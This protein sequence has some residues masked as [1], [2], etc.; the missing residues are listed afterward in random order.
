MDVAETE[1]P[2][3]MLLSEGDPEDGSGRHTSVDRK[4]T[5]S[6]D[7]SGVGKTVLPVFPSAQVARKSSVMHM[8]ARNEVAGDDPND[9]GVIGA[10]EVEA[11]AQE[12]V[13]ACP[14]G[15]ELNGLSSAGSGRA[16][17]GGVVRTKPKVAIGHEAGK[18][19]SLP[20]PSDVSRPRSRSL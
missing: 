2:M 7:E 3:A 5:A 19:M 13:C 12:N 18:G 9:T 15:N 17:V 1:A 4:E 10:W 11:Q 14:N 6:K 20:G 16:V 8:E